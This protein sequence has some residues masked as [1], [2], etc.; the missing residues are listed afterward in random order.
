M[1]F[2]QET[3]AVAELVITQRWPRVLAD[4]GRFAVANVLPASGERLRALVGPGQRLKALRDA[5]ADQAQWSPCRWL[6]RTARGT[7][8]IGGGQRELVIALIAEPRSTAA[9]D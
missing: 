2:V 6:M 8:T 5:C 7:G 1:W 9:H 4:S 3:S